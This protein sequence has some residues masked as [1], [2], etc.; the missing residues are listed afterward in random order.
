[1]FHL[2]GKHECLRG[3]RGMDKRLRHHFA[4]RVSKS[5][6]VSAECEAMTN[7]DQPMNSHKPQACRDRK[8]GE[9]VK[10]RGPTDSAVVFR[11]K[12]TMKYW[13]QSRRRSG[14][15]TAQV[16]DTRSHG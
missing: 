14:D 6:I 3:V 10:L 13:S 1:L 12:H 8:P 2:Y 11:W 5:N 15:R 9:R 4:E 7:K 16:P